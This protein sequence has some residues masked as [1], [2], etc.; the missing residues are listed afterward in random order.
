MA[1]AGSL[2]GGQ[3]GFDVVA[4][5]AHP[6][7]VELSAGGTVARAVA[8]GK[9]VALVD[10]TRGELGTR[11]SAELRE[12][13]A[14][15]AADVLGVAHR[16]NCGLPDGAVGEDAESLSRVVEVIRRLKPAVVLANALSDRHPDHGRA[17]ALVARACFLAGLSRFEPGLAPWRPRLVLHYIQDRM[18]IPTVVVDISGFEQAKYAAIAAYGSQFYT[19]DSEEPMTPISSPAFLE[20][21]R[22]KDSV[23]GRYV[24]VQ[25]GEGFESERPLGIVDFDSLF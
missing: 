13:E 4:F 21:L 9:R 3:E 11:G 19:P 7:D 18:R 23:M 24:G 20:S 12:R 10:L 22:G 15:A 17:A 8:A 6:D 5:G 1:N 25:S 14:A 16:E 2:D